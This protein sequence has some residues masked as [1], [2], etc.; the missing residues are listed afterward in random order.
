MAI[1]QTGTALQ[2]GF[3]LD[4]VYTGVFMETAGKERVAAQKVIKDEDNATMT[5]L[6][7]GLATRRTLRGIVKAS[8]WVEP[9]QGTIVT[10]NSVKYRTESCVTEYEREE[11]RVTLTVIKEDSLTYTS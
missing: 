4:D 8:G 1:T 9:R 10:I 11:A 2:V 6:L 3:G 5:V 7:S